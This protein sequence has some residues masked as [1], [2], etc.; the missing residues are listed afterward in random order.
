MEEFNIKSYNDKEIVLSDS[1]QVVK[2]FETL[3]KE[4]AVH[5]KWTD[6]NIRRSQIITTGAM[7]NVL[8][9]LPLMTLVLICAVVFS[10]VFKGTDFP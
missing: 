4:K 5:F 9:T 7:G 8:G 6:G 3:E 2:L 10:I 1:D